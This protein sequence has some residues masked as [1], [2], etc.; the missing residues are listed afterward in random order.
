MFKLLKK[1]ISLKKTERKI[2]NRTLFWLI[3]ALILVRLIPIKWFSN[4]LGVFNPAHPAGGKEI[5][6]DLNN[7]QLQLISVVQKNIRRL[8]KQLPWTVKCFE[9]AIAA[10]KILEKC[11]I[12]T[13]IYLGVAKKEE[14]KLIAHAWLKSGDVFITG[15]KGYKQYTVV[16]FY[17]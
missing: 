11:N 16:G 3:F 10:K 1:Y 6:F 15:K 4:L 12:K 7:K 2:L 9:E 8:K 17:T 5:K 14:T 13:T